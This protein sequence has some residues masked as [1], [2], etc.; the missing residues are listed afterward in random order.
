MTTLLFNIRTLQTNLRDPVH[1]GQAYC[2][3][4]LFAVACECP[5][6]TLT[7]YHDAGGLL[8][9]RVTQLL[10]E[11]GIY[12][13]SA[14][15]TD[16]LKL[17]LQN[18]KFDVHYV[19]MPNPNEQPTTVNANKQICTLFGF[20]NI[21]MPV[22]IAK[23]F[24]CTTSVEY[25]KW[26][27]QL[28]FR[29]YYTKQLIRRQ[30]RFLMRNRFDIMTTISEHTKFSLLG[31]AGDLVLS[32]SILTLYPPPPLSVD[33]TSV[34]WTQSNI[35]PQHYFLILMGSRWIKN[36]VRAVKALDA[37]YDLRPELKIKTLVLGCYQEGSFSVPV[38]NKAMFRFKTY[39]GHA[40]LQ[41][42][43]ANAFAFIYPTLNEGFGY[44]PLNAMKHGVPVIASAISSVPEVCADGALYFNP[45]S[46]HEIKSRIIEVIDSPATRQD[47]I[48]RGITRSVYM[49]AKQERDLHA[50]LNLFRM[51]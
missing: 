40:E 20:R 24:Y 51:N 50:H 25:M 33:G 38:K 8:P 26:L 10:I 44:P 17:Q 15:N 2:E 16:D 48:R 13:Y 35:E 39:V 29:N 7:V 45:F 46:I 36:A 41:T 18:Q 42:Y 9:E 43:F 49:L 14:Q 21:E 11:R 12:C 34:N 4:L 27:Y 30:R 3:S 5:D 22:D 1:G 31:F 32:E 23:R 37:I 6:V 28:L 47:L 19:C